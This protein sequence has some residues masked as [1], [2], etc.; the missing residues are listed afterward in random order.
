[1]NAVL[2]IDTE[3]NG[4][5]QGYVAPED[6]PD[7]WPHPVQVAWAVYDGGG[8]LLVER[9][10]IVKPD[11]YEID[12]SA[13]RVH[14]I[15]Q[16]VARRD[17]VPLGAVLRELASDIARYD[18]LVVAH[19]WEFDR[20][21]LAAS[22]MRAGHADVLSSRPSVCTMLASTDFCDL[23]GGKW[24][25]LDELFRKLFDEEPEGAH[26]AG[27]DVV[28]TARCFFALREMG[29]I[30]PHLEVA[31]RREGGATTHTE[32]GWPPV[33]ETPDRG[34][35][36][37]TPAGVAAVSGRGPEVA[38]AGDPP[39][40]PR[41][42]VARYLKE[43]PAYFSSLVSRWY[44]LKL[45]QLVRHGDVWEFDV[46]HVDHSLS[47]NTGLPWSDE[48]I[49]AFRDRWGYW[50]WSQLSSNESLPWTVELVHRF[51]DRW[52][53]ISLSAN[54]SVPWSAELIAEYADRWDWN[55]LCYNPSVPWS[56]ELIR[57]FEQ[58]IDFEQLSENESIP[59]SPELIRRYRE[60]WDWE[61]LGS[62]GGIVWTEDMLCEHEGLLDLE[63]LSWDPTLPWSKALILKFHDRW[64]WIGLSNMKRLYSPWTH[65]VID[66]FLDAWDWPRLSHNRWLPW[67]E[68]L[69]ERYK[70]LWDWTY[71]AS[72]ENLPWS[73][74]LIEKYKDRWV[75]HSEYT[76]I[77][78]SANR[79]LPWSHDLIARYHEQWSWKA[80]SHNTALP[81]SYGLIEEYEP[82]WDWDAL[83]LNPNLPWTMGLLNKYAD[84]WNWISLCHNKALPWSHA[85]LAR[86]EE[87]TDTRWD[88]I[89][90]N[91]HI[92]WTPHL[93]DSFKHKL[94]LMNCKTNLLYAYRND[95][96]MNLD[97][98]RAAGM[99]P[100]H[101]SVWERIFEPFVDSAMI[102]DIASFIRH[103]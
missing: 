8:G 55:G 89:F 76:N 80:L 43:H 85:L 86:F 92:P 67:S 38:R 79:V 94:K 11:G 102:D 36:Q 101:R 29:V 5:P 93:I 73:T 103:P 57:A 39:L 49:D 3:T 96:R 46:N 82:L 87:R 69:I 71:L 84:R 20:G 22:F 68:D 61:R 44:P 28:S 40:S 98:L 19:N 42:E 64:N 63:E 31:G 100:N 21:V 88:L 6:G 16:D 56:E 35:A 45:G 37:A 54:R 48:L 81:W 2:V 51:A 52:S 30:D 41:S 9:S 95:D 66:N 90:G 15:S 60:K 75:Y 25:R 53:W 97:F 62:N 14:G 33:E 12:E 77:G 34:S 70:D 32:S 7:G 91:N 17:G 50:G 23:P 58:H 4:L 1:M 65:E 18:P 74:G 26:S 72:N 59:W 27:G 99:T 78:L 83:S 13:A 10:H 47:N 24:P